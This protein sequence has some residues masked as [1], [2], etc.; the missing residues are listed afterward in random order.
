MSIARGGKIR[1]RLAHGGFVERLL[2]FDLQL[3]GLRGR[4]PLVVLKL[5]LTPPCFPFGDQRLPESFSLGLNQ[6]LSLRGRREKLFFKGH[7]ERTNPLVCAGQFESLGVERLAFKPKFDQ[8]VF[9]HGRATAFEI[10]PLAFE[11]QLIRFG[12]PLQLL[13]RQNLLA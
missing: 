13:G 8:H 3:L 2:A 1:F 7:R 5:E 6:L 10:D 9:T 4:V 11:S 12:L